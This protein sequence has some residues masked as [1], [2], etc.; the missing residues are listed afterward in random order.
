MNLPRLEIRNIKISVLLKEDLKTSHPKISQ[1][2]NS[3]FTIYPNSKRLINVTN[4][5]HIQELE[6]ITNVIEYQ[7]S[8]KVEKMRIDSIMLSRKVKNKMFSFSKTLKIITGKD[9]KFDNDCELFH[10]PWIKSKYGSFNLFAC[11][12]VTVMGVRSIDD[13]KKIE[14]FLDKV[15]CIENE[16]KKN[17][18]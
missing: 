2:G 14:A 9:F 1:H 3:I 12:S 8:V 13:L 16:I 10:A 18:L 17:L 7:F 5:K 4:L 15:Y 11:G 6:N